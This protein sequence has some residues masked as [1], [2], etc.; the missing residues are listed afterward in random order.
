M[1]WELRHW[2]DVSLTGECA[3]SVRRRSSGGTGLLDADSRET[4]G[5]GFRLRPGVPRSAYMME[6]VKP[7]HSFRRVRPVLVN[8]DGVC[9][10]RAG[11]LRAGTP[12]T[13]K[14]GRRLKL[15]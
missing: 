4:S 9:W 10:A 1:D 2:G 3:V 6:Q 14:V 12:G 13:Q 15:L 11:A 8:G 5:P 7:Q